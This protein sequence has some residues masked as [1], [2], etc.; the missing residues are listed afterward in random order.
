MLE[1]RYYSKQVLN[2]PFHQVDLATVS[3]DALWFDVF[4]LRTGQGKISPF[5]KSLDSISNLHLKALHVILANLLYDQE[6]EIPEFPKETF[7]DYLTNTLP[8]LCE[9]V[10]DYTTWTTDAERAEELVRSVFHSLN[11][12]PKNETKEYFHDRYRSIDSRER[13]R[14]LDETKKAQERAK[15]ILR[16]LKQKEEEEAA[17]KYNRE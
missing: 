5:P 8:K 15:E 14:I 6:S 4:F 13:M 2:T 11:L 7:F 10:P 16:Q 9:I 17:S 12:T 3:L 1:I